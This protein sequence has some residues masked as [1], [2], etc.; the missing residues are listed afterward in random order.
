MRQKN[1]AFKKFEE[2]RILGVIGVV[3]RSAS[4]Q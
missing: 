2:L 4:F 3:S 1:E